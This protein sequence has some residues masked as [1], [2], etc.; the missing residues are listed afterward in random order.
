MFEHTPEHPECEH[1]EEYVHDVSGIV[2]EHVREQLRWIEEVGFDIVQTKTG[3]Y[4]VLPE[5]REQEF[6]QLYNQVDDNQVFG[7]GR[8]VAAIE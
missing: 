6:H 3:H 5:L 4:P 1:I 2:H 8:P 7:Y